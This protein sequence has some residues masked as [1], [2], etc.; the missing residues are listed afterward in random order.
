MGLAHR[1]RP[2]HGEATQTCVS[3]VSTHSCNRAGLPR[4]GCVSPC[5]RPA[6]SMACLYARL[7]AHAGLARQSSNSPRPSSSRV[8]A[9]D[10]GKY[11][12]C[13][14]PRPPSSWQTTDGGTMIHASRAISGGAA[15]AGNARQEQQERLVHLLVGQP[16]PEVRNDWQ[17]RS[18]LSASGLPSCRDTSSSG[19]EQ[20][21]VEAA[22]R[23]PGLGLFA[24]WANVLSQNGGRTLQNLTL[25]SLVLTLTLSQ[26]SSLAASVPLEKS[27]SAV[28]A[29]TTSSDV[30]A[31]LRSPVV[32]LDMSLL[33]KSKVAVQGEAQ[34]QSPAH[35][36]PKG[37]QEAP[38]SN[39]MSTVAFLPF[40]GPS[41]ETTSAGLV[42]PKDYAASAREVT[43]RLRESLEAEGAGKE[44]KFRDK[45]EAAKGAIRQYIQQWKGKGVENAKVIRGSYFY[46]PLQGGWHSK[47]FP[48]TEQ[49]C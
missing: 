16:L 39:R 5:V 34:G 2:L 21:S 37:S 23:F 47:W 4:K 24:D 41:T 19:V 46:A 6:R 29:N 17:G 45:A 27:Y 30:D 48:E 15:N 44:A 32:P 36:R 3:P 18:E 8:N 42:L 11:V 43:S 20:G 40:G 33:G 26:G 35:D 13:C 22:N 7:P 31:D 14:K 38:A 10:V 1:L 9:A 49:I 25:A 12:K 28:S